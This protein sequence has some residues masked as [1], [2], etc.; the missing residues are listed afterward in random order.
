[1]K[2]TLTLLALVAGTTGVSVVV[3]ANVAALVVL[4]VWGMRRGWVQR[5]LDH[6]G[7]ELTGPEGTVRD[8]G[9]SVSTHT[10]APRPPA[11][12]DDRDDDRRRVRGARE[13]AAGARAGSIRHDGGRAPNVLQ[14]STAGKA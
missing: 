2:K 4:A 14:L 7:F 12:D 9:G 10:V 3:A 8:P 11:G 5:I 1:M 13:G 6:D